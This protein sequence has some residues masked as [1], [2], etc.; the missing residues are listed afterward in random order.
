MALVP[1][2]VAARDLGVNATTLQRWAKAGL[3]KPALVTPGGHL[4]WDLDNLRAQLRDARLS[5]DD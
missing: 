3:V 4:R 1:T 5:D 2:G